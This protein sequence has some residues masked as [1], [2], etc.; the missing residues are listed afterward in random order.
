MAGISIEL[1]G[2]KEFEAA[3]KRAMKELGPA[4]VQPVLFESAQ[5]LEG[6]IRSAAP[7]GKTGNLK[8][9]VV[10]KQMKGSTTSL[11][12]RPSIAA[13]DYNVAPHHHLVEYGHKIVGPK[14]N[15]VKT[16][17]RVRARSYFWKTVRKVGPGEIA[18]VRDKLLKMVEGVGF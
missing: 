17:K 11:A 3:L 18:S 13:E 8:K 5:R 2:Q 15:K 16:G 10:S 9:G 6:A 1:K 14:P 4:K 7:L 12:I